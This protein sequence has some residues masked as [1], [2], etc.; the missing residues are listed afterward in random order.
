MYFLPEPKNQNANHGDSEKVIKVQLDFAHYKRIFAIIAVTA[1][2]ATTA[3]GI[4]TYRKF[5]PQNTLGVQVTA[6][7]NEFTEG[8]IKKIV[9]KAS[10]IAVLPQDELP[11]VGGI[12]DPIQLKNQPFFENAQAGDLILIYKQARKVFLYNPKA[13]KI[14]NIG[15]YSL[16]AEATAQVG[17]PPAT[18]AYLAKPSVSPS[19]ANTLKTSLTEVEPSPTPAGEPSPTPEP[20]PTPSP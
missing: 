14:V 13:H 8:E 9:A 1:I 18:S 20:T 15:P 3:A 6:D 10:Q 17:E 4:Y 19:P 12:N 2:A 5:A 16:P 11:Q 7:S